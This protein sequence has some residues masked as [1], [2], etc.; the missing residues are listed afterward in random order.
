MFWFFGHKACGTLVSQ[1]RIKPAPPA[2]AGKVL[3]TGSQGK[4]TDYPEPPAPTGT[5]P[6]TQVFL[7]PV[8]SAHSCLPWASHMLFH[9]LAHPSL[10]SPLILQSSLLTRSEQRDISCHSSKQRMSQ[11]P[12]IAAPTDSALRKER[13]P[14]SWQPPDGSHSPWRVPRSSGRG[15]TGPWPQTAKV[16]IK[17]SASGNPGSSTF[18]CTERLPL[19]ALTTDVILKSLSRATQLASPCEW[20]RI[21]CF[22]SMEPL[23]GLSPVA[24][25]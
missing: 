2:W 5:S 1:L 10:L 9:P 20:K 13:T 17:G 15:N 11:A 19:T 25:A 12:A 7:L 3:T 21:T 4:S 16:Q 23:D 8:L 18:P 14:A 22:V 24:C 6:A